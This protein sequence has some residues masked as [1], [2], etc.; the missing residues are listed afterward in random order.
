MKIQDPKIALQRDTDGADPSINLRELII[1]KNEVNT[2]EGCEY[3]DDNF[4]MEEQP[5]S[6]VE[7][8]R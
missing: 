4:R 8:Q 1:P 2:F 6:D 7:E 5:S 3:L